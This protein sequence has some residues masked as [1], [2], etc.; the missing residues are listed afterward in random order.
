MQNKKIIRNFNM[1]KE[2]DVLYFGFLLFTFNKTF[3]ER[4]KNFSIENSLKKKKK[5]QNFIVK[6]I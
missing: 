1:T 4:F 2:I 5:I 3:F 6:K